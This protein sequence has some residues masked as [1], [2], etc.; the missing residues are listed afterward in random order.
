MVYVG[1]HVKRI[2]GDFR[3]TLESKAEL[4]PAT[5]AA[6]Q[7]LEK[8]IAEELPCDRPKRKQGC[9]GKSRRC[10]LSKAEQI[11]RLQ[12]Q[13]KYIRRTRQAAQ[14]KLRDAGQG[15]EDGQAQWMRVPW[16]VRVCLAQPLTSCRALAQ[17]HSDFIG[18]SG[19]R[20]G[21]GCSRFAVT[22]IEDA[23]AQVCK[24]EN[25]KEIRRA[26]ERMK[27][28]ADASGQRA[29]QKAAAVA[30]AAVLWNNAGATSSGQTRD[31][32]G[33]VLY[34]AAHPRRSKIAIENLRR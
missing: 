9:S 13:V 14:A 30:Q 15:K 1:I 24:E 20:K 22:R 28:E 27:A 3:E 12:H 29:L 23:F 25:A 7:V 18:S 19:G 21:V 34:V 6:F 26:V 11:R 17:A 31:R 8:A 33:R 4:Y 16:L 2:A 5:W 10:V 32:I